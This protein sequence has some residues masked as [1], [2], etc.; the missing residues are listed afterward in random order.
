MKLEKGN[1]SDTHSAKSVGLNLQRPHPYWLELR[2]RL[3]KSRLK[4]P[5]QD[6][7]SLLFDYNMNFDFIKANY[8][9]SIKLHP[10]VKGEQ[11]VEF[12]T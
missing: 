6:P 1:S 3:S 2:L 5:L 9:L 8:N 7:C 12:K 11:P 10:Q 4:S